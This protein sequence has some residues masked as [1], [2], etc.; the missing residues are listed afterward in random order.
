MFFMLPVGGVSRP[1]GRLF[2]A[3]RAV[4]HGLPGGWMLL[5][6]FSF[7]PLRGLREIGAKLLFLSDRAAIMA[8]KYCITACFFDL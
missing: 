6:W 2:P 1:A 3:C 7:K 5:I 4:F 8:Q